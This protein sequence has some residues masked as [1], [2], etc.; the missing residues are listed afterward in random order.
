MVRKIIIILLRL[1]M[2]FLTFSMNRVLCQVTLDYHMHTSEALCLMLDSNYE[3]SLNLYSE[4]ILNNK[5]A[6]PK[7]CFIASQLAAFL[8]KDSLCNTLLERGL[9]YGM[10]KN[11]IALNPHLSA[12]QVRF[13]LDESRMDSLIYLYQNSI[14]TVY[15]KEIIRMYQRDQVLRNKNE[16]FFNALLF[17]HKL[18][19]KLWKDWNELSE[20]NVDRLHQLISEK[21]FPSEF[22]I[23]TNDGLLDSS[24]YSSLGSDY[25][26]IMI[27]HY[28]S[29]WHVLKDL[30]WTSLRNGT[31]S[32]KQFALTRDFATRS[33][34]N[35][36]K[37]NNSYSDYKYFIRWTH[38]SNRLNKKILRARYTWIEEH[39]EEINKSRKEIGLPTIE[40]QNK[41]KSMDSR[42]RSRQDK[43]DISNSP[44]FDLRYWEWY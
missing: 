8:R 3:E 25:A 30:L 9:I 17:N 6:I 2:L 26:M 10:P 35:D 5:N 24:N 34:M 1:I 44:L 21:G 18:K 19:P 36:K 33:Y 22:T 40:C 4:V 31:I 29:S 14:D 7:D 20:D 43:T 23:G 11:E 28:D 27:A 16:T 12:Q 38:N 41:A 42:F 13:P 39:T 15:K 37:T 32:P